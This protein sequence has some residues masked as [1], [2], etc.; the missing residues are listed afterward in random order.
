MNDAEQTLP[1]NTANTNEI[2]SEK[3]T[4][5]RQITEQNVVQVH[6]HIH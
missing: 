2:H 6:T 5:L 3:E 4:N 1:Q